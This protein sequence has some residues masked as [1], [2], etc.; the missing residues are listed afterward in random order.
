MPNPNSGATIFR[1]PSRTTSFRRRNNGDSEVEDTLTGS[2][3]GYSWL[4]Y[5]PRSLDK[6]FFDLSPA[7]SPNKD[8]WMIESARTFVINLRKVVETVCSRGRSVWFMVKPLNNRIILAG[9][10]DGKTSFSHWGILISG[11]TRAQLEDRIPETST[12]LDSIWGD[13]H[14]LRNQSGTAIYQ[15]TTYRAKDY[16]QATKLDYLGQTEVSDEEL[17]EVGISNFENMAKVL[18]TGLINTNPKYHLL[19]NNCQVWVEKFLAKV[20]PAAETAKTIAKILGAS[21]N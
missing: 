10:S 2:Q 17:F 14:E 3:P 1:T 21:S 7:L 20:C 12:D 13:L 11:L 9:S 15:C 16:L 4:E 5:I 8:N 6:T 18:G 19:K